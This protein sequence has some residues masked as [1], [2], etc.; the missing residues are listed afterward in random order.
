MEIKTDELIAT[1]G[2]Q[3]HYMDQY[4]AGSTVLG[5][6]LEEWHLQNASV[7]SLSRGNNG[8]GSI[9]ELNGCHWTRETLV[10]R[11]QA[12]I[13]HIDKGAN[14]ESIRNARLQRLKAN[15]EDALVKIEAQ[16]LSP[17]EFLE[18]YPLRRS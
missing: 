7:C 11:I 17:N 2:V 1:I 10:D 4:R 15:L 6:P 14:Q 8:A 18:Q 9:P 12:I 5:S 16:T 3:Q 13:T